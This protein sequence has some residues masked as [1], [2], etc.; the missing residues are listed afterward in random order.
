MAVVKSSWGPVK[1]AYMVHMKWKW[2]LLFN[3]EMQEKV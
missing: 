2:P 3:F 1:Y